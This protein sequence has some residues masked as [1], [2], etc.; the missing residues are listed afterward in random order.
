[1]DFFKKILDLSKGKEFKGKEMSDII[2]LAGDYLDILPKELDSIAFKL[3]V[4][5]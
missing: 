2:Y 5:F 3:S 4:N 1:M